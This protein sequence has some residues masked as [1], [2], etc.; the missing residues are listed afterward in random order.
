MSIPLIREYQRKVSRLKGYGGRNEG[1]RRRHFANLLEAYCSRQNLILLEELSMKS[2]FG[3][4]IIPDGTA[5]GLNR[6]DWGYWEAKDEKDDLEAEINAKFAAGYPDDNIIFEDGQN[7]VLYQDTRRILEAPMNNGAETLDKLL[8]QFIE[9]ERPDYRAFREALDQ[10]RDAVPDIVK[11]LRRLMDEEAKTN[12]QFVRARDKFL[13]VCQESINPD[14]TPFDVREMIV[15]HILTEDIFTTIFDDADFHRSNNIARELEGVLSTFF[16]KG[17]KKDFLRSLRGYYQTMR[18]AAARVNDPS[19]KQ[20]FLK[21][22]YEEFYKAYN[23]KAADRLGIVY[24]PKEIVEF[25]IKGT[26]HLLYKHFGKELLSPNVHIIDPAT[27]TGVFLTELLN[28]F[29]ASKPEQIRHKYDHELHANEVS[30]LPYYIANLNM[31][32]TYQRKLGEYREFKNLV[33]ADT[34]DNMGF[35]FTGKQ[36]DMFGVSAENTE[37]IKRQNQQK[38]SVVIGNPPYNAN[39]QNENDNNKNREYPA[40]DKRIKDTY[41]KKS[42]AQKTKVYDMYSR[43]Y[44]WASDRLADEGIIA[45]VTNRSFIDSRTFDGFRKCIEE[46]FDHVYIVDT[47]SDVRANP[48]IAGTTHNVFGI[49]TGVAVMFLVKEKKK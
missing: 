42:T 5:K 19:E 37:R 48:K 8:T 25:M 32:F 34:L 13:T 7:A 33:F 45:F 2:R 35:G 14:M 11:E 27:G 49:Q 9:F 40:I 1:Q 30:I 29:P 46:E 17:I 4:T 6:M 20:N 18:T 21:V 43:F 15:Q 28:Y 26:D 23:P 47:Q 41:V 12:T 44:R 39:Q 31:E 10:F 24:T 3:N 16:R 36:T 38:I 22:V